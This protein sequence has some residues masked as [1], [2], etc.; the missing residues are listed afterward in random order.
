MFLFEVPSEKTRQCTVNPL[1]KG[2]CSRKNAGSGKLTSAVFRLGGNFVAV[3]GLN[4]P[5]LNQFKDCNK[6]SPK[7]K[8]CRG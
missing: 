2:D 8:H 6:V 1:P 5:K 7:P 4:G 3:L